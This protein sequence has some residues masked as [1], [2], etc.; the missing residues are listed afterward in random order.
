MGLVDQQPGAVL[1]LDVA[2]AR[3]IDRVA[4]HRIE[5]FHHDQ[6]IAVLFAMF[7]QQLLEMVEVVVAEDDLVGV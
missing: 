5:A 4:V 1:F 3:Q 7:A 2:D 6:R